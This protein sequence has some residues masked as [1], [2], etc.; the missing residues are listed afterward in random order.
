MNSLQNDFENWEIKES[1]VNNKK[2]TNIYELN[3]KFYVPK[4]WFTE[5]KE[6]DWF[7]DMIFLEKTWFHLKKELP[8]QLHLNNILPEELEKYFDEITL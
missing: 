7:Q 5:S 3:W 8:K 4:K 1:K 2:A 6:L